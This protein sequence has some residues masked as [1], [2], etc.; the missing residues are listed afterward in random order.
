[1]NKIDG[2]INSIKI[3]LSLHKKLESELITL[4]LEYMVEKFEENLSYSF[5]SDFRITDNE[6][7]SKISEA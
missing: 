4:S 6:L 3:E 2:K 7:N 5:K 1:M